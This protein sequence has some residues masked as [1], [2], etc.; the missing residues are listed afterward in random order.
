MS[1]LKIGDRVV[2]NG[3]L[4]G[5]YFRD[6]RGK[7]EDIYDDGVLNYKIC[8]DNWHRG[9]GD[10]HRYWNVYGETMSMIK[11][12]EFD[13]I[14]KR[15]DN[16]EEKEREVEKVDM[17]ERGF[18]DEYKYFIET[19]L[20]EVLALDY[21]KERAM[22]EKGFELY[23]PRLKYKS[24][25][26]IIFE[27]RNKIIALVELGMDLSDG[28][29]LI[30]S[31]IDAPRLDVIPND[32]IEVNDD[33]VFFK[34]QS[35]GGIIPQLF[36][37]R[38]LVMVGRAYDDNGDL[39]TIN[40]INDNIFFSV[41]SLLPHLQGRKEVKE[42]TSEKLKVR[43]SNGNKE[44][45]EQFLDER[46]GLTLKNLELAELSFVPF[47][48]S[49][50]MGFDKD[51]ITGYSHDDK[52]CAFAELEAILDSENNKITKIALFTSYEETGSGQNSGAQ[53]QFIDDIFLML[54]DG[55]TLLAR[56]CMRNT[57][58]ISADVCAGFDSNYSSHFE[59]NAKAVCGKGTT[60]VPFLGSKRGNDSSLEFRQFIKELCENND[61][62]YQIETT[63]PSE[64]GGGTVSTFFATRGMEAIDIAIPV[65][66][67]HSSM[68]QISKKDLYETYKLYKVFLEN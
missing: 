33:G 15:L 20:H 10:S 2:I 28:S 8:F 11:E 26:K 29:N 62:K 24:G 19:K 5:E 21:I 22:N 55:N 42:M 48:I 18:I 3:Y 63:K 39:V 30:V 41:T 60:I 34:T 49:M 47:V 38:P 14:Q 16:E 67:M 4:N 9:W 46:Y 68:E 40:T 65:L 31:H 57:R 56:E 54:A 66:A 43:M 53:S 32:P 1:D 6:E 7:I 23:N 45:F 17:T 25:D 52:C 64:G 59:S 36:L 35:Y 61:I 44:D 27:S 50:D 58:V 12:E 37:D 13:L 51:L